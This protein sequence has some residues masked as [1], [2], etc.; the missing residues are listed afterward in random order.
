MMSMYAKSLY[1]TQFGIPNSVYAGAQNDADLGVIFLCV[2]IAWILISAL[3]VCYIIH[4]RHCAK[5]KNVSANIELV[6]TTTTSTTSNFFH[7]TPP[8]EWVPQEESSELFPLSNDSQERNRVEQL[9]KSTMP[10]AR[11]HQIFRIQNKWLW[12]MY[13]HHKKLLHRKNKG[14]VNEK[15]LFHGT[16]SNDPKLIYNGENGFDARLSNEGYWGRANYFAEKASYSD[17]YAY[18]NKNYR[19]IFLVK[20]LTG[21]SA[22]CPP[23]RKLSLPP[24]KK[25]EI[26]GTLKFEKTRYDSVT[27][28][29][30]GCRVYMTYENNKAYPAYLIQYTK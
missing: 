13:A 12:E 17:S 15:E 2:F 27:G 18:Q 22:E 23:N 8:K 6:E 28:T 7:E 10:T 20:V 30:G 29:T 19:E 14:R 3:L 26:T 4:R 5:S 25:I 24:E 11:I 16:R 9:F 21:D 1:S